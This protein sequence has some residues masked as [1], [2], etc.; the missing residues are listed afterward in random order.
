MCPLFFIAL[1]MSDALELYNQRLTLREMYVLR[2]VYCCSCYDIACR[3]V[4]ADDLSIA[5]DIKLVVG[6]LAVDDCHH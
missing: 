1:F 6:T 4:C 2:Q 5:L 3:C